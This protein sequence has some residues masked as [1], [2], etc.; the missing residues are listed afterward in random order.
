MKFVF[1]FFFR[2]GDGFGVVGRWRLGEIFGEQ[3]GCET[4]V[5]GR[6]GKEG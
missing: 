6:K 4:G 2:F 5:L 1:F 3:D